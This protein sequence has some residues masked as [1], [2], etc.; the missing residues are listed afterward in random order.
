MPLRFR[1][2]A[3]LPLMLLAL[4][5]VARPATAAIATPDCATFGAWAA[6]IDAEDTYNVAPKLTLPRALEDARL[7]PVFGVSALDWTKEDVGAAGT[8][9]KTCGAE[10]KKAGDATQMQAMKSA[11]WLLGKAL[12]KAQGTIGKASADAEAQKAALVALPDSAALAKGIGALLALDPAAPD[13]KALGSPP[14]EI[15]SPL[16]RLAK[17]LVALPDATRETL[18][19]ALAE[20]RDAILNGLAAA[21]TGAIDTAPADA[22]GVLAIMAARQGLA[23]A[24]PS[25]Q[26]DAAMPASEGRMAAIRDS[27]RAAA[28]PQ[29]VPPA[30]TDL[31]RWSGA[32]G[33]TEMRPLGVPSIRAAF[34]DEAILPVFG[35][36]IAD[37]SDADLARFATLRGQCQTEWAALLPAGTRLDKVGDDAPELLRLA[38]T[39]AWI[40]RADDPIVQARTTAATYRTAMAALDNARQQIAALP[41]STDSLGQLA[42]LEALPDLNQA[43]TAERDAYKQAVAAKRAAILAKALADAEAGLATI[44][45]SALGDFRELYIYANTT[46]PR[47]PDAAAQERLWQRV[48]TRTLDAVI[49]LE[50]A[51]R[52]AL[53]AMPETLDGLRQAWYA[54]DTLTGVTGA[55]NAPPFAGFQ[56]LAANRAHAIAEAVRARNCAAQLDELDIDEDDAE[57]PL[58]DGKQG[59]PFGR[60]VCNLTSGGSQVV[61]FD[62]GSSPEIEVM[63]PMGGLTKLHLHEG[64]VTPGQDMLVGY[65]VEDANGKRD[66][67]VQDWV[68]FIAFWVGDGGRITTEQSCAPL[69]GKA[70]DDLSIPERMLALDCIIQALEDGS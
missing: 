43:G 9:I 10:A 45:V 47:L 37:W 65:R 52:D 42:G 1:R 30:C 19:A 36:P 44:E 67:T 22:D 29:W 64:E 11:G 63:I 38:K 16:A 4:G 24:G 2:L 70:E 15:G 26:L 21:V 5:L 41:D 6:A 34:F 59:I 8:L 35:L 69:A 18:F 53:D 68:I 54:T 27:L 20:R 7:L 50:P 40:D 14:R 55:Q 3:C 23:G 33:A 12:P 48:E 39:G 46:L 66:V 32:E 13:A 31:Y 62:G 28:P 56:I 51:F 17:D 25:A 57:R 60:F 61:D 58:W 49:K